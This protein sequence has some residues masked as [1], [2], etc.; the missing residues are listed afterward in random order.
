MS[1]VANSNT[2]RCT[3]APC[4]YSR[5]AVMDPSAACSLVDCARSAGPLC[6]KLRHNKMSRLVH[7]RGPI[8]RRPLAMIPSLLSFTSIGLITYS[9]HQP[10]LSFLSFLSVVELASTLLPVI[11]HN[12]SLQQ[13]R[14]HISL[15]PRSLL[16]RRER[17]ASGR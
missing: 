16:E 5:V 13:R 11:T 14:F 6:V 7:I 9:F 17:R 4:V 15:H 10:L 1:S 8:Q 3:A 2:S 12:G